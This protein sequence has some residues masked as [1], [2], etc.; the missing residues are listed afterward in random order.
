MS[1]LIVING[2]AGVGK[3]TV[4]SIL[5]G[6]LKPSYLLSCDTIRR[7]LNDYHEFPKQGRDLRNRIVLGVLDNLLQDDLTVILDQL[8][9]DASMLDEYA[10]IGNKHQ[11]EVYEYFL[12]VSSDEELLHRFRARQNGP[13]KHPG[14][15][16][17]EER[18]AAYWHNMKY[19]TETR[20]KESTLLTDSK[21]PQQIAEEILV[22]SS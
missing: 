13:S 20:N 12:W 19:L 5:H 3:S 22:S 4:A 18:V 6:Q 9:T 1:K 16:L 10:S 14:S 8:H 15:S 21:T 17:T 2:P 11:A 7:F